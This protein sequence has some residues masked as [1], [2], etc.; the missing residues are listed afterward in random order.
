MTITFTRT[1]QEMYALVM[2][3]LDTVKRDL[4]WQRQVADSQRQEI[5]ELTAELEAA[6]E[7]IAELEAEKNA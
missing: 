7:R 6:R 4:N 2:D 1:T 3:E 5:D